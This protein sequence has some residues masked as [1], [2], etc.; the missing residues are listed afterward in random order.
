[1]IVTRARAKSGISP[2]I[3]RIGNSIYEDADVSHVFIVYKFAD[4][5]GVMQ[6]KY[7]EAMIEDGVSVQEWHHFAEKVDAHR[8]ARFAV[9][10]FR[11]PEV[12]ARG[13][14]RLYQLSTAMKINYDFKYRQLSKVLGPVD[15]SKG[16]DAVLKQLVAEGRPKELFCSAIA[17]FMLFLGSDG[18]IK[19]P[20]HPTN[21]AMTNDWFLDQFGME[22][23]PVS[24]PADFLRDPRF[25]YVAWVRD[26]VIAHGANQADSV[27]DVIYE[28]VEEKNYRFFRDLKSHGLVNILYPLRNIQP[29]EHPIW[30]LRFFKFVQK[31]FPQNVTR[32]TLAFMASMQNVYARLFNALK[33][34]E[35]NYIVK[36]A[37]QM[38]PEQR[39]QFVR[40]YIEADKIT[41][42]RPIHL[43]RRPLRYYFA[44]QR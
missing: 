16:W 5:K 39:R 27:S 26:P 38:T 11:E 4:K 18:K 12:A 9:V 33:R 23:G 42:F 31:Q 14:E 29:D 13:A 15:F 41:P 30:K 3:S 10:R 24:T 34:A 2:A 7:I 40:D 35:K 1:M 21:I 36:N 32:E 19:V 17:E 22:R 37:Q 20:T 25:D 28:Y 6:T 8:L 43:M 44:P